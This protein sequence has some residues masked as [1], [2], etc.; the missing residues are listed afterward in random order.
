[1][2]FSRSTLEVEIMDSGYN[3]I[4]DFPVSQIPVFF[5]VG[6]QDYVTPGELSYEFYEMLE[7]PVKSFMWFEDSA[8]NMMYDESEQFNRELVRLAQDV[9]TSR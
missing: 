7:A 3:H 4:R 8:H 5:F 9:L 6:H 2:D 1:M